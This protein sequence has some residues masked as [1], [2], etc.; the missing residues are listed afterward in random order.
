MLH[1]E[2]TR[3]G[4]TSP[5]VFPAG[6]ADIGLPALALVFHPYFVDEYSMSCE[7]LGQWEGHPACK[8][9]S[10]SGQTGMRGCESM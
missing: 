3:N 4:S 9:I 1:M 2:E 8:S 5:H 7:G 10:S 6:L